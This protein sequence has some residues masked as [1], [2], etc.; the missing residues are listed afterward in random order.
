MS[1]QASATTAASAPVE[2]TTQSTDAASPATPAAPK[3]K[4][5][6]A[7]KLELL[8]KRERSIWHEKQKVAQERQQLASE[9]KE[10]E[11]WKAS[12]AKAK[13]N[14]LE[15]LSQAELSYD[16]LTNFMLNGGKPTPESEIQ[17]VRSELEALRKERD[18]DKEDSKTAQEQAQ[19]QA[20][21]QRLEEF[22]EEIADFLNTNK[23]TYELAS[24]RE[25]VEDIF[26]TI[27][28]AFTISLQE[29]NK[30]GRVGRPPGPMSIEEAT[31]IVEEFYE[32]EVIRL[33]E[34]KKLKER[35]GIQPK[36]EGQTQAKQPSKTLTNN[37]S[38][39]AASVVPAKNDND[40]MA[41]ALAK[42]GGR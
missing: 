4:D 2:G 29:Y 35:L 8:T 5:Q 39:T 21:A 37:M 16:E 41:R 33:A 11:D 6:F 20:E 7:E 26:T 28:D 25:A 3:E 10:Y 18:K 32:A 13:Q 30:N 31:K 22:K 40:R 19:R 15:Y 12:K 23:D 34:T 27:T 24:T 14:P 36:E 38:S 1:I 17:S 9:R 42:L